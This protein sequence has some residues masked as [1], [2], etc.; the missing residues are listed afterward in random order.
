YAIIVGLVFL[1]HL[2]L[3]IVYFAKKNL[4]TDA[5]KKLVETE[6]KSYVSLANGDAHSITAAFIMQGVC[7]QNRFAGN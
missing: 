2:I 6:M 7:G 1:I 5:L 4:I 3:I